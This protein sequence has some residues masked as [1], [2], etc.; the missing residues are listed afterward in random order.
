MSKD[1]LL[2]QSSKKSIQ[3]AWVG[4][5]F[6]LFYAVVI[7]YFVADLIW[8]VLVPKCVKSPV[9]DTFVGCF[10]CLSVAPI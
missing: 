7:G 2:D 6:S 8:V 9:G 3:E 5:W 4:D 10:L 1:I